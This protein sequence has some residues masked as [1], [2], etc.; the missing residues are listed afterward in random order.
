M[1]AT[2]DLLLSVI[3]KHITDDAVKHEL[4]DLAY[5]LGEDVNVA[6]ARAEEVGIHVETALMHLDDMTRFGWPD[7]L[8][9]AIRELAAV[10]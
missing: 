3:E 4:A 7:R 5:Q 1:P 8:D 6:N 2:Y 9:E 10:C